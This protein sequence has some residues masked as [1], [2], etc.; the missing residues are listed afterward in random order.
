MADTSIPLRTCRYKQDCC[1]PLGATLP[2]TAEY[3]PLDRGKLRGECREC[4]KAYQR[5]YRLTESGKQAEAKRDASPKRKEWVKSYRQSP[6]F[7]ERQVSRQYK[8]Y[9]KKY[10]KT[11]KGRLVTNEAAKRYRTRHPSYSLL[12]GN[13]RRARR[14]KASG[15]H[16]QNDIHILLKSQKGLCWWCDKPVGNR[17]H[18]DHRIPLTRGGSDAPENLCISCPECNLRKQN[19]L[20]Q[21]WN[22]R[23]L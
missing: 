3:F 20:P 8:A 9:R 14:L 17:Y 13:L 5:R 4:Y 16:T 1:N 12:H 11:E 23:L 6:E 15:S 19:K 7:K 22:G 18:V 10:R 21:E 2:E